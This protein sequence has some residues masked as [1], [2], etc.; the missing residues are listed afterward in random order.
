[1]YSQWERVAQMLDPSTGFSLNPDMPDGVAALSM[2]SGRQ[3][4][5]AA[6]CLAAGYASSNDLDAA[7]AI[8][9]M[10]DVG[11]EQRNE[12]ELGFYSASYDNLGWEPVA[13]V[14]SARVILTTLESSLL[15]RAGISIAD[16]EVCESR[17]NGDSDAL[18]RCLAERA[19]SGLHT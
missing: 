13:L 18:M 14:A 15:N 11:L 19:A 17:H 9:Q 3:A 8:G 7:Y 10:A 4:F 6:A 2:L 5:W 1:M 16:F 12:G